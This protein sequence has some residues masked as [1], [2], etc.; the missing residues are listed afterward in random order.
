MVCLPDLVTFAPF[1]MLTTILEPPDGYDV[2]ETGNVS[3]LVKIEA[4]GPADA[5][6]TLKMLENEVRVATS[7][8]DPSPSLAAHQTHCM[9]VD[10]L[11]KYKTLGHVFRTSHYRLSKG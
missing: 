10:Y 7:T 1:V 11:K 3:H 4:P 9:Y 2:R 5:E 6:L 8:L